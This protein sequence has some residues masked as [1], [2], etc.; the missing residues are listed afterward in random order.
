MQASRR[1]FLLAGACTLLPVAA[2]A[3]VERKVR[4]G[5]LS[6]GTMETRGHL[7]EALIRSLAEQGYIEGRNLIVERRYSGAGGPKR[8]VEAASEL[9][10]MNL[11]A[12]VTTCTPST[13]AA[14]SVMSSTPIVMAAVSDPVGQRLIA[15]LARP[16][17]NVTGLSS[18]GEELL[19]KMMGLF[20]RVLPRNASVAVLGLRR[21]PMHPRMWQRLNDSASVRA[22][23]VQLLRVDY[24]GSADLSN[25]IEQAIQRGANA[26]F[27][28]GD[29]PLALNL[30]S[31]IVR[32]AAAHRLPDFYW[33]REF[34]DAGGLMSYGESLRS[35]YGG[36]GV[37]VA[38]V[39]KGTRPAD[40]PV[41]QPTKFELILNRK[42]AQ[43]LGISIPQDL[44]LL[45]DQVL[46]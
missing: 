15:S 44:A 41:Q 5:I 17:G 33:A 29:D 13:G 10:A 3:Q 31:A 22:L 6:S 27:V 12:V 45:A 35:G 14:K 46:D 2:R 20:S 39:A 1:G 19:P 18:Q 34:V 40:L 24:A 4:I 16:G 37:Y 42:R 23:G 26:L 32:L 7:E 28:L 36:A 21:N 11:D 43:A 30:R 25:A 8:T 38:K 9:A